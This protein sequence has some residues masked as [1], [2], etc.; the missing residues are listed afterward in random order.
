[1]ETLGLQLRQPSHQ[2]RPSRA[3]QPTWAP[4][5]DWQMVP[6]FGMPMVPTPVPGFLPPALMA[7]ATSWYDAAA[8]CGLPW[9]VEM[10]QPPAEAVHPALRCVGRS[11]ATY[12]GLLATTPAPA[13]ESLPARPPGVHVR[14]NALGLELPPGLPAFVPAGPPGLPPRSP[15][16]AGGGPSPVEKP[17]QGSSSEHK[18]EITEQ[19][20]EYLQLKELQPEEL[21]AEEA[22]QKQQEAERSK[23]QQPQ[24]LLPAAPAMDADS[25]K[26]VEDADTGSSTASVQ[27]SQCSQSC[28]SSQPSTPMSCDWA[29]LCDGTPAKVPLPWQ[30]HVGSD[31]SSRMGYVDAT[32][33]PVVAAGIGFGTLSTP[34]LSVGPQLLSGR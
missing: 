15:T 5:A 11:V 4:A 18:P 25:Q 26:Y 27:E 22:R 24:L 32:R 29:E 16:E 7:E 19:E 1:M 3:M 6:W 10:P 9:P 23:P 31:A 28:Q 33:V 30:V 12:G 20:P 13:P 14:R 34:G 17:D 2:S 8:G 21:M